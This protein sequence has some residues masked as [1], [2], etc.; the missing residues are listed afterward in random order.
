MNLHPFIKAPRNTT[1]A[2][3]LDV[4]V[5][6]IPIAMAS[7]LAYGTLALTLL[8]TA[9][10]TA[11]VTDLLFS[12]ILFGNWKTPLDGTSVITAMLLTFTISPL[13]PW[14]VVAFGAAAAILFGKILW[15]G[16]GKNRFNPALVGREFMASVFP[17]ILGASSIWA[18]TSF[19][20]L[21]AQ[22]FFTGAANEPVKTYLSSLLYNPSGALGEYSTFLIVLGGLYLT[23]RKRISWHIPT[24]LLGVF[25]I[26]CV[27]I[28]DTVNLEYSFAGLLFGTIFMATD[29]PSSPNNAPGKIYY[30]AMIGLVTFILVWSGVKFSYLSYSILILNGFSSIISEVFKPNPWGETN[31]RLQKSEKI[32]LLTI[33]IL[34]VTFAVIYLHENHALIYVLVVYILY[35]VLKY[36]SDFRHKLKYPI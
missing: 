15:G 2:I 19:I 26:S 13:T 31:N 4:I 14:F 5:A 34:G 28:G 30:G 3:M 35:V 22:D 1:Q 20:N 7:Y 36:A 23:L 10:T 33:A 18:T 11:V 21:P 12:G 9:I 32:A 17:S 6:L 16:L 8:G 24:M 25:A 29:M 27:V